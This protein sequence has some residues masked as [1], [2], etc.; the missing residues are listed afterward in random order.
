MSRRFRCDDV[1]DD[2]DDDGGGGEAEARETRERCS[3]SSLELPGGVFCL[4]GSGD[5]CCCCCCCC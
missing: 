4:G 1:V 2:D 3:R 5:C